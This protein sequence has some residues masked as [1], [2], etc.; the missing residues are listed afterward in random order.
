MAGGIHAEITACL[1]C[2]DDSRMLTRAVRTH[3]GYESDEYR[4]EKGHVFG[5]D[6]SSGPATEPQW[7][8]PAELR[9]ALGEVS[10][11]VTDFA[12]TNVLIREHDAE[13]SGTLA[14][15]KSVLELAEWR[16]G[17]P[18]PKGAHRDA[19][20]SG[21]TS[22]APGK[23]YI[24]EAYEVDADIDDVGDFFAG[25]LPEAARSSD[26]ETLKFTKPGGTVNILP[27]GRRTRF[28]LRLG[29]L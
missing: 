28:T 16:T 22:L 2:M 7:P 1:V 9:A 14:S 8:P 29:P 11:T 4:C 12:T 26:G 18:L 3:E 20:R 13:Q 5:I 10:V 6:W 15:A 27:A 25:H 17:F 19:S 21:A 23:N 24:M